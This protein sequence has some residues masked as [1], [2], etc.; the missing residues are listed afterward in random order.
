MRRSRR[1]FGSVRRSKGRPRL[2]VSVGISVGVSSKFS[3]KW[4][5]WQ[6]LNLRP[7][8]PN[9]RVSLEITPEQVHA[10]LDLVVREQPISHRLALHSRRLRSA[11]DRR[12]GGTLPDQPWT[13]ATLHNR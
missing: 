11:S 10:F 1:P 8:V 12:I 6:D 7:L 5:E 9:S 4:S 13:N 3:D 2:A